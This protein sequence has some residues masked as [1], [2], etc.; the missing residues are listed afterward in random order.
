V[1]PCW[2]V[3]LVPDMKGIIDVIG[4][5]GS[6]LVLAAYGL[7]SYQKL[8]TDSLAFT[9][10]NFSGGIFLIIYSYYYAAF[11]STFI[12]V[13][14]VLVAIPALYKFFYKK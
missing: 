8:K 9:L 4:W 1:W 5:L 7:T 13:V 11:A 14:W 6:I 10:L 12:N 3:N 2:P